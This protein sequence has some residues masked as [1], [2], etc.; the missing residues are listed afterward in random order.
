MK[1]LTDVEAKRIIEHMDAI[2]T[3]VDAPTISGVINKNE[4]MFN[5][6]PPE[7]QSMFKEQF[8]IAIAAQIASTFD[9]AGKGVMDVVESKDFVDKLKNALDKQEDLTISEERNSSE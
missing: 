2:L 7:L 3:I 8:D 4:G 6:V 9:A 5:K 1:R